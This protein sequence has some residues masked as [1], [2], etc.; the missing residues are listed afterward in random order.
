VEGAIVIGLA[1]VPGQGYAEVERTRTVGW[2]SAATGG[3]CGSQRCVAR[4]PPAEFPQLRE[5]MGFAKSS[6]HPTDK[7]SAESHELRHQLQIRPRRCQ[8]GRVAGAARS[9]GLLSAGRPLRHAGPDL[10]PYHGAHPGDAGPPAHQPLWPALQGDHRLEPGQDRSRREYSEQARHR[11]RHQQIRLRDPRRNP[12]G[13]SGAGLRA[14]HPYPCRHGSLGH[15]MR[16]A[17]AV[18][19]RDPV[20]GPYRLSRLRRARGRSRRAR[21]AGRGSGTPRR[22]DHAQPR[23]PDLRAD[24]PTPPIS[25]SPAPAAPTGCWNGPRCCGCWKPRASPRATRPTGSE[26]PQN[27]RA[28]GCSGP[29]T[30][31]IAT[32]SIDGAPECPR[33]CPTWSIP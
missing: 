11:L 33:T 18:A 26:R 10:Q 1:L 23:P 27:P 30:T 17:A 7:P 13:A 21:A 6:T 25:I 14:A 22:H 5:S 16:P 4:N 8:P 32:I 9:R 2:V 12:P 3:S 15:E 28:A 29:G 24:S 31:S 19:D 20:F